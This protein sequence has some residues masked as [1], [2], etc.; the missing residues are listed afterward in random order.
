MNSME[1][2]FGFHY[3]KPTP[4]E[5]C[6]C[7]K[8]LTRRPLALLLT[9]AWYPLLTCLTSI[10]ATFMSHLPKCKCILNSHALGLFI[11]FI[12]SSSESFPYLHPFGNGVLS[13]RSVFSSERTM[14][15]IISGVDEGIVQGIPWESL[16]LT[17]VFIKERLALATFLTYYFSP[18]ASV[19]LW[20]LNSGVGLS[21]PIDGHSFIASTN[22][23]FGCN[24]SGWKEG[25]VD[26]LSCSSKKDRHSLL[27]EISILNLVLGDFYC[28]VQAQYFEGA[29]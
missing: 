14:L 2:R 5:F 8:V 29:I 16:P 6:E 25:A 17:R 18:Q 7:S 4:I 11:L 22:L 13:S 10:L 12:K 20:H 21:I 23:I 15:A 24:C 19:P 27:R 1:Q 3:Y 26:T 28:G 9:A